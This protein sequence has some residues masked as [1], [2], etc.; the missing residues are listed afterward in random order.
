V[1]CVNPECPDFILDGAHGEYVETIWQCPVCG[2]TL[3]PELPPEG[4]ADAPD[5]PA[6]DFAEP[7]EPGSLVG[8]ADFASRD[9]AELA[10]SFL[11]ANGIAA[12]VTRKRLYVPDTQA[13][14]ALALLR[15]AENEP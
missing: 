6:G 12:H 14:D 8:I 15:Q 13:E 1:F 3:V 9:A 7:T 10:R 2:A 5:G 11:S 4:P